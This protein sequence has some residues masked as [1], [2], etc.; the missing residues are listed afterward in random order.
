MA[1]TWDLKYDMSS[2]LDILKKYYELCTL[3]GLNVRL[4]VGLVR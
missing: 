2:L 4:D 3:V 1:C